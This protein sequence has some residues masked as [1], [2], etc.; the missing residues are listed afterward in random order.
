MILAQV[1][2]LSLYCFQLI[3]E[4][5]ELFM[6]KFHA[7]LIRTAVGAFWHCQFKHGGW[8]FHSTTGRMCHLKIKSPV[9]IFKLKK[10]IKN[11]YDN[12]KMENAVKISDSIHNRKLKAE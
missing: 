10:N 1:I 4:C 12:V 3:V 6:C 9:H 11:I 8:F 5:V 2:K 7:Y